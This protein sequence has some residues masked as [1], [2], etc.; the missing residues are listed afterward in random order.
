MVLH[1]QDRQV[2][3]LA[4][5]ADRV[6]ELSDL[7][8]VQPAGGL[9]EQQ[10]S[11]LRDERSRELDS[12]ERPER[13][14]AGES[15]GAVG[16]LD[17]VERLQR[18]TA[19]APLRER[20]HARVRADEEVLEDGHVLEEDDV[21]ERAR[22][23]EPDDAVRRRASQVLA[24][25]HDASLVRAVEARDEVEERCLARAVRADQPAD[26]P[27]VELQRHV[28][29]GEDAAEPPRDVLYR[30]ERHRNA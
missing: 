10:E 4:D 8:V 30:Q 19:A 20:A 28:G 9:V 3:V 18:L 2:E 26:L 24:V 16:E 13:E 22:D 27:G 29:E 23:A 7:L 11:R 14:A 21:L 5:R 1:E 12:L 17:V 25:E 6:A 15:V